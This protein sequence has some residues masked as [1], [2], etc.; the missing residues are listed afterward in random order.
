MLCVLIRR[1]SDT[2]EREPP[3]ACKKKTMWGFKEK[4][5]LRRGQTRQCVDLELPASRS[6]SKYVSVAEAPSLWHLGYDSPSEQIQTGATDA[7]WEL[8][9]A[10]GPGPA[11]ASKALCTPNRESGRT[12]TTVLWRAHAVPRD[13]PDSWLTAPLESHPLLV[14]FVPSFLCSFAVARI[15]WRGVTFKF[16]DRDWVAWS[17]A[18]GPS[19]RPRVDADSGPGETH[20]GEA[21]GAWDKPS[22]SK[23]CLWRWAGSRPLPETVV[24]GANRAF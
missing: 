17:V 15:P 4:S 21:R 13:S 19:G 8:P 23:L 20:K 1:H 7:Q 2:P 10:P 24:S 5:C 22:T 14:R 12:I 18:S 9:W 11:P 3:G 6:V 16:H